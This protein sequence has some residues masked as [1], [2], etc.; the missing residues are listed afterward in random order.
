MYGFPLF[1]SPN[2]PLFQNSA[3]FNLR[4][5]LCGAQGYSIIQSSMLRV[6]LEKEMPILKSL[7]PSV[8]NGSV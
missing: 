1:K 2:L 3:T 5:G 8:R 7:R 6:V 4:G